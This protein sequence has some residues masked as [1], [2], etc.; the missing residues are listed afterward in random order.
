[1]RFLKKWWFWLI[2]VIIV[3]VILL[4]SFY[5]NC[6]KI[7]TEISNLIYESNFCETDSDCVVSTKILNECDIYNLLNKNKVDVITPKFE[8]L[9]KLHREKN[10]PIPN[11]AKPFYSFPPTSEEVKC[12][13]EKCSEIRPE[14]D[15]EYFHK[16]ISEEL[17]GLNYCDTD[18]DCTHRRFLGQNGFKDHGCFAYINKDIQQNRFQYKVWDYNSV[19]DIVGQDCKYKAPLLLECKQNKCV[20]TDYPDIDCENHNDCQ[21][22]ECP[23][24]E[25][26]FCTYLFACNKDKKCD[27]SR[28]ACA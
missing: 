26:Y 8:I 22:L 3:V 4:F 27:C 5:P 14:R 1:M 9:D 24:H 11:C 23:V 7:S 16:I 2:I 13:N 28:E 17:E 18:D 12:V 15:C 6:E 19:C 25:D 20:A 10:C 21:D